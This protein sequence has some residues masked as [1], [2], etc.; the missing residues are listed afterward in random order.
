MAGL[1]SL[2]FLTNAMLKPLDP[3]LHSKEEAR[4]AIQ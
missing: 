4:K 1:Y 2:A 3:S